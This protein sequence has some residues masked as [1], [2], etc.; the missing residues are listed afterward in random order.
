M[1]LTT[2]GQSP[3]VHLWISFG[4]PLNTNTWTHS[5]AFLIF[6]GA[7]FKRCSYQQDLLEGLSANAKQ[8]RTDLHCATRGCWL[9]LKAEEHLVSEITTQ[10]PTA[11]LLRLLGW[12]SFGVDSKRVPFL[13][14]PLASYYSTDMWWT[15]F[16]EHRRCWCKNGLRKQQETEGG[17]LLGAPIAVS[18][19]RETTQQT[20]THIR[21]HAG[22]STCHSKAS[23]I[24]FPKSVS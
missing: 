14:W 9:P 17:S 5:Y 20:R 7:S 1:A 22:V 19:K 11:R 12:V 18:L 6:F 15:E 16:W 21:T 2:F 8:C 13:A 3:D 10:F 23:R 24:T 4:V